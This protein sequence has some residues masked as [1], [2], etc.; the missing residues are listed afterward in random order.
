MNRAKQNLLIDLLSFF[1]FIIST[2]SGVVL[3]IALPFGEGYGFQGG[4]NLLPTQLF[5]NLSRHEWIDI[6]NLSSL[7]FV[8]LV[9]V[10][11]TQHRRGIK[12]L[13]IKLIKKA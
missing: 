10:H 3:W 4:R 2:I 5:W 6:H 9:V 8:L 1:A 7:I 12:H 13:L 11:I